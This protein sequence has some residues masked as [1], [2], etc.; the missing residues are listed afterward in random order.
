[1]KIAVIRETKNPP[2]KRVALP[3]EQCAEL[4]RKY[5]SLEIVVQPDSGRSFADTEYLEKGIPLKEDVSDCDILIGVKEVEIES[6]IPGKTYLF[7]SHT[8]KKQAHNRKL[9]QAALEKNIRLIDYEYLTR[10]DNS[11]VVAFGRWAGIVGAYN[12]LL[13]Y[14]KRSGKFDLKAAWQCKDLDELFEEIRKVRTSGINFLITG[15]GRVAGGAVE[16]LKGTQIKEV[17]PEQYLNET[18]N[19][20]VFSR[21]DP[22]HY[23]RHKDGKDFDLNHFFN[24]PMEYENSFQPY[25]DRTDLLIACHYWDPRSPVLMTPEDMRRKDFRISIIADVSC[26]I[27]GPIPSTL[28]ASSIKEPVYGYNPHTEK[29][30]D[31]YEQDSITVMAVDNLPGELPRNASSDFGDKLVKE[32][33]P[34]LSGKKKGDMTAKATITINGE[35]GQYFTY[36]SDFARGVE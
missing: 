22:W 24:F 2:D 21:I 3:P 7:F 23:V 35:L 14:G 34:C 10:E 30:V 26:D 31:P 18:F 29:E 5:P 6:L 4:K 11:R 12:G 36:L 17:S 13:Q 15:G 27:N 1:M 25:T 20:S 28:R 16:I 32:V 19:E 33:F 8:A 9:L